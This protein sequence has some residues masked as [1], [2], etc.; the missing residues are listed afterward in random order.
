MNRVEL[1]AEHT[2]SVLGGKGSGKTTF[3]IFKGVEM[4][5]SG[6]KVVLVDA[7]GV[8]NSDKLKS[9]GAG[10]EKYIT[11]VTIKKD[12]LEALLNDFDELKRL[13]K[14]MYGKSNK[15]TILR[16]ELTSS[17][18]KDFFNLMA[19]YIMKLKNSVL[20]VDEAQEVL[21]QSY[22]DTYS[23]ELER[24]IRVGRNYNVKIYLASQRPQFLSKKVMALSDVFYFGHIDYYLDARICSEIVGLEH[25][26]S[27]NNLR[28]CLKK[29]ETGRFYRVWN[30]EVEPVKINIKKIKTETITAGRRAE[31]INELNEDKDGEINEQ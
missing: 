3:L 17:E 19:P 13:M 12:G 31:W 29:L 25:S 15:L 7:G 18:S 2:S 11:L 23:Q 20:M 16:L 9:Y 30:S 8:I 26:K 28:R 22:A 6:D 5:L 24:L 4:A 27:R 21:P 14:I 1:M 10:I